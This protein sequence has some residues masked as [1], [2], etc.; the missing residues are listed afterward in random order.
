M[1]GPTGASLVAAE[2]A[3]P[4]PPEGPPN[5]HPLER[6]PRSKPPSRQQ[7]PKSPKGFCMTLPKSKIPGAG[8]WGSPG[9][10]PRP[11]ALLGVGELRYLG[12][13]DSAALWALRALQGCTGRRVGGSARRVSGG[14]AH[15]DCTAA[16]S[17][18]W[19]GHWPTSGTSLRRGVLQRESLQ[20][21]HRFQH[22]ELLEC[23][24]LLP[25]HHPP[26]AGGECSPAWF[27]PSHPHLPRS[28]PLFIPQTTIFPIPTRRPT[29]MAPRKGEPG[30]MDPGSSPTLSVQLLCE[31][32]ESTQPL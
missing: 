10:L 12:I 13:W 18:G 23:S 27:I 7:E 26:V 6:S 30:Q 16:E 2:K 17:R 32:G 15:L 31:L 25:R 14:Q 29:S 19:C 1:R 28:S 24:D 8:I 4:S 21:S 3:V 20:A 9:Q 22:I 5:R 11:W